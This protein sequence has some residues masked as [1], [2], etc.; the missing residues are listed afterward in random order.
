MMTMAATASAGNGVWSSNG[1]DGGIVYEVRF[2]PNVVTTMYATTRGG[3]FR[4]EDGGITWSASNDGLVDV[5]NS[6]L[7][8]DAEAPGHL[9][10][11][12]FGNRLYKSTDYGQ[13]WVP[14]GFVL[15]SGQYPSYAVDEPA[16]SGSFLMTV[17]LGSCAATASPL[18]LRTTDGGVSFSAPGT[19]LPNSGFFGIAVEAGSPNHWIVGVEC[20]ESTVG[21]KLFRS[22]DGGNVWT[23]VGP[24]ATY[25]TDISF[26]V[27]TPPN[28][29]VYASI[30]DVLHKSIDSGATWTATS[31]IAWQVLAHPTQ[32]ATLFFSDGSLSDGP[33]VSYD[34]GTTATPITSGLTS[35]PSYVDG[36]GRPVIVQPSMFNFSPGFP[37]PGTSL[38]LATY[39]DG[40]FRS[41]DGGTTWATSHIGL[42]ASNIRALAVHPNPLTIGTGGASKYIFG[43][44]GDSS[45]SSPALYRSVDTGTNWSPLNTGLRASNLRAV[46]FDPTT[47]G[48][49]AAPPF[50]AINAATLYA[51]GLSSRA[52]YPIDRYRNAGLFKSTNGGLNWS[53]IDGGLPRTPSGATSYSDLGMVRAIALDP[54]SCTSPPV[55]GPCIAGPLR[56]LWSA[57]DG[58]RINSVDLVSV[59]GTRRTATTQ[60][61]QLAKSLDGG[62]NWSPLDGATSGFPVSARI[63]TCP[64]YP[65]P[66]NYCSGPT[67]TES[68]FLIRPTTVALSPTNSNIAYVGTYVAALPTGTSPQSPVSGMYKTTDGGAT[69]APINTGLPLS[70]ASSTIHHSMLALAM[71]P[72][73]DQIL[74]VTDVDLNTSNSGTIYKTIDGG[75]SWSE[76]GEGLR[77]KADVRALIVDASDLSGN[78]LYAS[79]AGTPANPGAVYKSQDGGATWL[80]ISVGLPADSA[81]SIAVDPFNFNVVHAGTNTG[82]WSLTQVPDADGDGI[83]DGTENNAPNGGDGNGDTQSDAVQR[84][85]GSTVIVIRR[86]GGAGGFFTSDI[87]TALS[88]PVETGGCQQAVDVQAQSASQ[89]GRDYLPSST[90]YFKYPRDLARF[91]VLDCSRAVVDITFHNAAFN[92]EYGWSFRFFGPLTPGD[93]NSLRWSDFSSRAQRLPGS[94]TTWR[95]TLDAN[96]FGSYRPANNSI[97][98]VGG[99]ACFDDRL[100]RDG[101]ESS[102][103]TGPPT[104]NH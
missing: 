43:G 17:S 15:P 50:P 12:D 30:D 14:T 76:S 97:L 20:D 60:S 91:E 92:T 96:Q 99:P 25:T 89:F 1:P 10:V 66:P 6:P 67:T 65:D 72:T 85:V 64:A 53:V 58:A 37:A 19:G 95:L 68:Y 39:G 35:N 8:V 2:D 24:D 26:G 32:S 61:F 98:F 36:T 52:G 100:F 28:R 48:V 59:P 74:W 103:D 84:D 18:L 27:G 73:N 45:Y 56:T 88:T 40:L 46:I 101:L 41:L 93:D 94:P 51:A 62:A 104:C 33:Q 75:A 81:L 9:Y 87:Q 63:T 83:P 7:V 77:G 90:Q 31:R 55:S 21:P 102:P 80:S 11:F 13:S 47:A 23:P 29:T 22:I 44:F 57:S 82:V 38:W 34:S 4:S 78:T 49:G 42:R 69:W 54:R 3:F 79:G 86:P 71:H 16:S 70:G 5:T